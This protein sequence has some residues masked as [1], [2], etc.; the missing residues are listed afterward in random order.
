MCLL[1]DSRAGSGS[2]AGVIPETVLP[3][4]PAVVPRVLP[5][6]PVALLVF[7]AAVVALRE[8]RFEEERCRREGVG[9]L[10]PE[11]RWLELWS[12]ASGRPVDVEE[13]LDTTEADC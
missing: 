8:L 11:S 10:G 9:W 3:A 4:I 6:R 2:R 5:L 13:A 1:N 7:V 12:E